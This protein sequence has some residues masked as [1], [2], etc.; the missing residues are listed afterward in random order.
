MTPGDL[1]YTMTDDEGEAQEGEYNQLGMFSSVYNSK[2]GDQLRTSDSYNDVAT[3]LSKIG[4]E[5]FFEFTSNMRGIF[6][7]KIIVGYKEGTIRI[8][9][10]LEEMCKE[11]NLT[12]H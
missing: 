10:K 9:E 1:P 4:Q 5:Y 2:T 11:K 8:A 7:D 3:F 12:V 6:G